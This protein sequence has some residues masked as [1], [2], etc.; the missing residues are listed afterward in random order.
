MFTG[1][2]KQKMK[3]TNVFVMFACWLINN[4]RNVADKQ[5]SPV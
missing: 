1:E 2:Y 5:Q 3:H 4:G